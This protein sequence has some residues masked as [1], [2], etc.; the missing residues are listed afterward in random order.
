MNNQQPKKPLFSFAAYN[1]NPE[2]T[3]GFANWEY[4]AWTPNGWEIRNQGLH[5][6]SFTMALAL[7]AL[8]KAA[9]ESG[10]AQGYATLERRILSTL[11]G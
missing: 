2:D 7:D 9:W 1:A 6:A 10:E 4:T 8:I 11:K 3:S 5:L